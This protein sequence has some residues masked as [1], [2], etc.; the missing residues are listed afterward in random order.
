MSIHSRLTGRL[1]AAVSAFTLSLILISAT[2]V[3]PGT[4]YAQTTYLG[5]IA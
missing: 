2:V 3:T 1:A 4:A 5:V